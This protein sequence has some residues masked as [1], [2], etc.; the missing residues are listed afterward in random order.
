MCRFHTNAVTSACERGAPERCLRKASHPA[1]TRE[2]HAEVLVTRV[3]SLA[4]ELL[5]RPGRFGFA[6]LASLT[7]GDERV[8][9]FC[10]ERKLFFLVVFLRLEFHALVVASP[11]EAAPSGCP[12][13]VRSMTTRFQRNLMAF[14][15][16]RSYM[17]K[18]V[19][20]YIFILCSLHI[21]TL[22]LSSER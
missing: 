5:G 21:C 13:S 18:D 20:L 4:P 1:D 12:I 6:S 22:F 14:R 15:V 16:S 3:K 8:P 17:P 11:T 10:V 9:C 19:H 7:T 2:R